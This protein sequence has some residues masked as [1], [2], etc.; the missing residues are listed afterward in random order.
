MK[1]G[2]DLRVVR[3]TVEQTDDNRRAEGTVG[4][5]ALHDVLRAEFGKK[6]LGIGKHFSWPAPKH[7]SFF[8]LGRQLEQPVWIAKRPVSA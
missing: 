2:A 8:L 7:P 3:P 5:N 1:D 4:H 6:N